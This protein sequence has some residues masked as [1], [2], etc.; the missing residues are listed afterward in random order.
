[1]LNLQQAIMTY[2]EKYLKL[3]RFDLDQPLPS[4]SLM[5]CDTIHTVTGVTPGGLWRRLGYP[6]G[7]PEDG[8]WPQECS[9]IK[10]ERL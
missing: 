10:P 4:A 6:D 5:M 9:G 7:W 1:M 3:G 8:L 2:K